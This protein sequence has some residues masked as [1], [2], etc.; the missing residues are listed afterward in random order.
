MFFKMRLFEV[1]LSEDILKIDV[2]ENLILLFRLIFQG[3]GGGPRSSKEDATARERPRSNPR[4]THERQPEARGERESPSKRKLSRPRD[5][6]VS[7]FFSSIFL[8][9]L[10]K[11]GH[12]LKGQGGSWGTGKEN[13][14]I[15]KW[16][17]RHPDKTGDCH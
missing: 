2:M 8:P 11:S 9:C 14:S 5:W 17:D 6:F 1:I 3:W 4:E 13:G 12:F 10:W 15:R 16:I 7:L